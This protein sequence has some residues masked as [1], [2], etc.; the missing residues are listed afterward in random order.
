MAPISVN[1][2]AMQ[3]VTLQAAF[4]PDS[5]TPE[6]AGKVAALFDGL[7][8]GWNERQALL[9]RYDPLVD[10]LARGDVGAGR[11]LEV[12]SGTG[13]ATPT[14]DAHFTAV[15]SVDL[16]MEMLRL[17]GGRRV[18][19]DANMTPFADAT[20][21]CAVFVNA[22]LFPRE[23]ARVLA[24]GATL[25]WVNTIGADTPIH[26]PPE[27]VAAAMG[28]GW[29]GVAAEAGLGLWTVLRHTSIG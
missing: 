15:I 6:R 7:A 14:L 2:E 10:A 4:E 24:P 5:W 8:A 16:S 11:C 20:F 29:H 21:D 25:V 1:K 12:G 27:D 23:T 18:L 9:N 26:L 19:G 22:I 17:A 3:K 13:L 28:D